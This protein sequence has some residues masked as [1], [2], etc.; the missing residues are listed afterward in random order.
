M[1]GAYGRVPFPTISS[2]P[3]PP[4][5]LPP[6]RL[7]APA[8]GTDPDRQAYADLDDLLGC[9]SSF[10]IGPWIAQAKQWADDRDA[11]AAYYEWMAKSQVSTWW[12]V[13]PSDVGKW[14]ANYTKPPPLD[15][16]KEIDTSQSSFGNRHLALPLGWDP[17]A[18]LLRCLQTC[19]ARHPPADPGAHRG[20]A[21]SLALPLRS[22][23]L[24]RRRQQALE[25]ARAR[26]LR[27]AGQVL[28]R[29]GGR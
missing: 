1:M 3:P 20:G 2:T 10:L 13:A 9:D 17:L 29:P 26:L 18:L 15:G 14:T 8:S 24:A 7:P 5:R 22:P 28:R 16:C 4:H 19:S 23:L 11:P 27:P 25:R 6:S 21:H 12:P